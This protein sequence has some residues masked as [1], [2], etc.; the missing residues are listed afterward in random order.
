MKYNNINTDFFFGKK[1]IKLYT[2]KKNEE[3]K[4]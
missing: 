2:T 1:Y 3:G 4:K